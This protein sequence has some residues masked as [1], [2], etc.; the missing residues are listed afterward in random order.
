MV[1]SLKYWRSTLPEVTAT[2]L[3]LF[4]DFHQGDLSEAAVK[5]KLYNLSSQRVCQTLAMVRSPENLIKNS[6]YIVQVCSAIGRGE[7]R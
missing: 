2:V 3:R 1:G 7:I 4:E 5:V 6:A